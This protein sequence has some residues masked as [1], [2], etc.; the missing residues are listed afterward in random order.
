MCQS[1]RKKCKGIWENLPNESLKNL[2]N[3]T[4]SEPEIVNMDNDR[5]EQNRRISG[6]FFSF[7]E[8]LKT[9]NFVKR[10]RFQ[11]CF[12]YSERIQRIFVKL[13]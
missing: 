11:W 7:V 4:E 2:S 1:D 5:K 12:A 13:L 6:D 9:K 8:E 3:S 10:W